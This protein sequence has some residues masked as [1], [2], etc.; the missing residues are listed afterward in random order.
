MDDQ[1]QQDQRTLPPAAPRRCRCPSVSGVTPAIQVQYMRP[2]T[3]QKYKFKKPL[4]PPLSH[5]AVPACL[6]EQ[7]VH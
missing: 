6:S 1:R 5:P 7:K 2:R 4:P 3:K